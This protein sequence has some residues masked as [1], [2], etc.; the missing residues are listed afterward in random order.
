MAV[1]L[2]TVIAYGMQAGR[3]TGAVASL[4]A[5][6]PRPANPSP[7]NADRAFADLRAMV[8]FGP[9]PA[10]SE[11]L[12][13]TRAYIVARTAESRTQGRTRRIRSRY[14]TRPQEDDQHPRQSSGNAAWH[15]RSG[16]SLRHEAL[17]QYDVRRRKRRRIERRMVTGNGARHP[18]ICVSR[19]RWSSFSSMGKRRLWNGPMTTASTEA[20]TMSNAA[21]R[22]ELCSS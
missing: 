4:P 7:F 12:A 6:T 16:R 17:R 9:R 10:G 1:V 2:S 8:A 18:G 19:T 11:A 20:S 13:K 3:A 21:A 14:T 15:D 5:Q 22:Q